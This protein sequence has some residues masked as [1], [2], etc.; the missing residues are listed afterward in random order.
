[1]I[2]NSHIESHWHILS[3]IQAISILII[4]TPFCQSTLFLEG[5]LQQ[6]SKGKR[7]ACKPLLAPRDPRRT[8]CCSIHF[9]NYG[10]L[11]KYNM[12]IC[13]FNVM[14]VYGYSF[15]FFRHDVCVIIY[16][17]RITAAIIVCNCML[18][19]SG[20]IEPKT[21][22]NHGLFQRSANSNH[23]VNIFW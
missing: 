20:K 11:E 2:Y 12:F 5:P 7:D 14:G 17:N 22:W 4:L 1:M 21:L 15:Y 9:C 10:H 23:A 18:E 6:M 16:C 3:Y 19:C 8:R 13:V